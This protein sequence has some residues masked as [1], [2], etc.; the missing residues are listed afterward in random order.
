MDER[1][2]K[3]RVVGNRTGNRG[4]GKP[5]VNE[6]AFNIV[7]QATGQIEKPAEKENNPAAM[8]LGRL[9]GLKGG[10]GA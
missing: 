3:A 9:G 10:K 5:D 1:S 7:Q 4:K 8:S 6:L 2:S